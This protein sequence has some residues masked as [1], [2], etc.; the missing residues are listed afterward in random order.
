VT[1]IARAILARGAGSSSKE[2]AVARTQQQIETL[3]A[4]VAE[5][6]ERMTWLEQQVRAQGAQDA[7]AD[8]PPARSVRRATARRAS[9]R[10]AQAR[11]LRSDTKGA[12]V[13]FLAK[14]PGSTA[15]EVAKALDLNPSTVSSS[16]VALAKRGQ[17][18][19]VERGYAAAERAGTGT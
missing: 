11:A 19:K 7:D 6:Q 18:E 16:L 15:G 5:L 3:E 17:V 9:R 4:R 13:E 12:I 2:V 14:H 10:R 1:S 8:A